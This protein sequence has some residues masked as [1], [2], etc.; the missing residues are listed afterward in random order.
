VL[1]KVCNIVFINSADTNSLMTEFNNLKTK[2]DRSKLINAVL[3]SGK[4]VPHFDFLALTSF[5]Q[6]RKLKKENRR[7]YK[8]KTQSGEITY[9][10]EYTGGINEEVLPYNEYPYQANNGS[11]YRIAQLINFV[12]QQELAEIEDGQD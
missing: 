8:L 2:S 4:Y 6:N 3:N 11:K 9:F 5:F 7:Y 12:S 10:V 1:E